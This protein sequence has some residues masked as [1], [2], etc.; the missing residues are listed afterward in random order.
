[1]DAIGGI[2]GLIF[3]IAVVVGILFALR[4]LFCW[5][6]KINQM[7]TLQNDLIASTH[8]MIR[9]LDDQIEL[10]EKMLKTMQKS[11]EVVLVDNT[12]NI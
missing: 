12:T 10:Q 7:I 4:E 6:W 9:K 5:Y 3:G 8:T 1:M 11:D 2:V